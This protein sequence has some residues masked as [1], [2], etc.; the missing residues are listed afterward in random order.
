MEHEKFANK[1]YHEFLI[2]IIFFCKLKPTFQFTVS[3]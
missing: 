2:E 1:L 3:K